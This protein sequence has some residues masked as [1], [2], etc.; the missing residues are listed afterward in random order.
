[1][2]D[3]SKYVASGW[4]RDLTHILSCYY[5]AQGSS[6]Q[7]QEWETGLKKFIKAMKNHKDREWLDIKELTQLQFMP[8]VARLF[9]D[10]TSIDLK[11]LGDYMD[12]MGAGSYYHWKLL[13]M[14]QLSSCPRLQ[15]QPVPLGPIP[16]P[17]G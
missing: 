1:M 7:S 16:W 4:R 5:V 17:S 10:I 9:H 3:V 2:D 15:G 12:W 11:G 13:E 8:Y 14:G 6:L